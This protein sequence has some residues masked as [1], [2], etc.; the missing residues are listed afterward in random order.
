MPSLLVTNDF[1]PKVG[2]IQ[3]YLWE[4]WRRLPADEVTVLTT[5]YPGAAEFDRAQPFRVVRD[6][7]RVLLPTPALAGRIDALALEIGAGVIFLDPALPL[8]ALGPRLVA[9][10]YVAVLHGAEVTV[11]GRLPGTRA[12]L[13]RVLRSAAGVLAAGT[14]PAD[15]AAR[16][17]GRPLP[18]LVVPPGVDVERFR[19]NGDEAA[20]A[21]VRRRYG[22]PEAAPVVLGVSRLVPR[23]GFDVLIDAV[24]RLA[25]RRFPGPA[26]GGDSS[27]EAAGAV[28]LALAGTGRDRDR[29]A[30]RAARAGIGDRFHLLGRVPDEDLAA[31][32][33]ASDVFAMCCRERWGGLEAEGFGIV[34]LE[35]AACGLPAVAGGSGG[36]GEAVEDGGTGFVVDPLDAGAVADALAR[37]LDDPELRRTMGARA[38]ARAETSFAYDGLAARLEPLARG[39]LSGL[40]PIGSPGPGPP[41]HPAPPTHPSPP[42]RPAPPTRPTAAP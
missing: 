8:G 15:E 5:P 19:P 28:H 4:L 32:Y 1:P 35:A 40:T 10:P 23:K 36:A 39:D 18:G 9:A 20:R 27:I 37:L 31:V 12:L 2:G 21:A 33:S 17:A 42:A 25:R 38:R 30:R 22:L 41:T 11:P 26:P 24:A 6:R 3:S 29:L 13:R 34:F 14:Y 16:G 7:N